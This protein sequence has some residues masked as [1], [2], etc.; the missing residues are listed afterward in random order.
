LHITNRLDLAAGLRYAHNDQSFI[1]SESGAIVSPLSV[2]GKSSEGVVT[3]SVSPSFHITP[4]TM[5]YA[6]IASGYQPGGP[7]VVL[8]GQTA[9]AVFHSATLTDYQFGVKSSF[10]DGRASVDLSAFY[11][12][13]SQIQVAVLVGSGSA[14]ENAGAARSQGFDFSGTYSP[15]RGLVLGGNLAYT[16]AYLTTPVPSIATVAGARLPGVPLWSGSLT[17]EYSAPLVNDWTGFIGGGYRYVG[18]RF[19][20][21]E[22]SLANGTPQGLKVKAYNVVDMHVGARSAG[23]TLSIFAKNLLDERA[24]LSPADYFN[25][26]VIGAPIDIKAPVLQPRTVGVS[27]DKSF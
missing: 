8:P 12:D 23:W 16:D 7:N 9:P 17:A 14:I 26:G 4:D 22:D 6:R 1:E 10:L 2:P 19:S 11:I 25:D 24:Y 20:E 13:W 5:V 18:P 15:V 3:F 21:V 27:I